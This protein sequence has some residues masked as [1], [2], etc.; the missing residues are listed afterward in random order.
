MT[1]HLQQRGFARILSDV[2]S[3]PAAGLTACKGG[4]FM[5]RILKIGLD[6][7]STNF[8]LCA[9][10]PILGQE[11]NILARLTVDPDYKNV[12]DFINK[13]IA[14]S[15]FYFKLFNL[16]FLSI[17]IKPFDYPFSKDLIFSLSSHKFLSA[18]NNIV[19]SDT[20][21]IIKC[22]CHGRFVGSICNVVFF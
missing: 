20:N 14:Y 6:V 8:T 5:Y 9:V 16:H 3:K 19:F 11:E 21:I 17:R 1:P 10:E 22:S 18:E 2:T 4:H 12:I 15:P 7:H 13:P